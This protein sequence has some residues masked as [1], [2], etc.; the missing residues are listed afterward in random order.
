MSINRLMFI[1]TSVAQGALDAII[2]F[3]RL[4]S[5]SRRRH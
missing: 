4:R 5:D 3:D 2:A 1:A